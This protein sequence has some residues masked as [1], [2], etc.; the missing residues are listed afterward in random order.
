MTDSH[1]CILEMPRKAYSSPPVF[2]LRLF[3]WCRFLQRIDRLVGWS[4]LMITR[5]YTLLVAMVELQSV[6]RSWFDRLAAENNGQDYRHLHRHL[7][8][9]GSVSYSCAY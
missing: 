3:P 2:P 4:N 7:R 6:H 8:E 1:H 9:H 5:L